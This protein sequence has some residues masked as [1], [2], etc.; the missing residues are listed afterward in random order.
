MKNKSILFILLFIF[1]YT[2]A[3]GQTFVY[4]YNAQG[5]CTSRI[6]KGTPKR[7]PKV[8]QGRYNHN[9]KIK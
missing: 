9:F 4:T 7:S 5:G 3:V 2:K 1:T 8:T 6:I